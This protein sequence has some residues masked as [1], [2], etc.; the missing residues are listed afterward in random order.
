MN[1][2]LQSPKYKKFTQDRNQALEQIN[3][4]TQLDVSRMLFEV[5]DQLTGF[6][7]HMAIQ[8]QMTLNMM[9]YN[10]NQLTH[11]MHHKFG[12]LFPKIVKRMK[13]G[14]KAAYVLTY[15]A[16]LEAIA[17][18]TRKPKPLSMHTFKTNLQTQL[19]A[20]TIT[21]KDLDKQVWH[22]MESLQG[23]ILQAFRR[24]MVQE[25]SSKEIV[26]AVKKSYPK[27]V[28]Y[29]KPPRTLKPLREADR[30][31]DE[32][33]DQ[34]FEFYHELTNDADWEAAVN[35]YKDTELPPSRFDQSPNFDPEV[36]YMRY[37]WELEQ[38][39]NDDFVQSVRG[40]QVQAAND[41]GVKDF[42]W[43]AVIDKKTCD[44]CCLPRAG[45]TTSEIEAMLQSGDLDKEECDA[46][47]PPAHPNCRCDIA[48]V[49]SIDE[50]E[51]ASWKEFGDWLDS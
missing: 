36:G 11:Y 22:S 33:E 27:I 12:E 41:L 35:A 24:A 14:R 34:E 28:G 15:F 39:M 46:T 20:K 23:N 13:S 42:V 48:P 5:L 37:S 19:N 30:P 45:K 44:V 7:S 2:L 1:T 10:T 47:T 26:T 32:E 50:V 8:N 6:I 40:G 4:N 51:G 3:L 16:E 9:S 29:R 17:R 25:L 49:S 38:D 31:K 18:A 43:V 21:G